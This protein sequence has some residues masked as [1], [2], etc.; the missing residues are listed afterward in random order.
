MP[1]STGTM[2]AGSAGA[3]AAESAG[4]SS[5]SSTP[6]AAATAFRTALVVCLDSSSSAAPPM[7]SVSCAPSSLQSVTVP[8]ASTVRVA[9]TA[10]P[11]PSAEPVLVTPAAVELLLPPQAAR[12]T[13]TTRLMAT[14]AIS[15]RMIS[16][17]MGLSSREKSVYV[18]STEKV[19]S[20]QECLQKIT[21]FA[22]CCQEILAHTS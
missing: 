2:A 22:R 20:F 7:L 16:C 18:R 15:L 1:P 8:L 6:S 9:V 21:Y 12:E 10:P 19:I 11:K 13:P 4:A 3:A 14:A 17:F 5:A